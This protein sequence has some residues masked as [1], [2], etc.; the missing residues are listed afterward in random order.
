MGLH[1]PLPPSHITMVAVLGYGL[2]CLPSEMKCRREEHP[3]RMRSNGALGGNRIPHHLLR[4]ASE[5]CGTGLHFPFCL[6]QA[7]VS[8]AGIEPAFTP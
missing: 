6:R 4:F 8:P 1:L 7:M 3:V 5:P 2:P